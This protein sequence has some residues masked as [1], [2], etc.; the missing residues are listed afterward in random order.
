MN[1]NRWALLFAV[2]GK[3]L[4]TSVSLVRASPRIDRARSI[5]SLL[6]HIGDK[7]IEWGRRAHRP[8]R[9]IDGFSLEIT[10]PISQTP[11]LLIADRSKEFLIEPAAAA[12]FSQAD[13]R[14]LTLSRCACAR[15]RVKKMTHIL[16]SCSRTLFALDF[17]TRGS[18][19]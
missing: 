3:L 5:V 14:D 19:D 12:S 16:V 7:K 17:R 8:R 18:S 1:I 10:N 2:L 6:L 11:S 13:A 4:F 15:A 9:D